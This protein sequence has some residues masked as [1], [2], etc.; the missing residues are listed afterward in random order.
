M[1]YIISKL[2]SFLLSPVLYLFIFIIL[3]FFSKKRVFFFAFTLFIFYFFT[4]PFIFNFFSEIIEEEATEIAKIGKFDYGILLGGIASKDENSH[5]IRYSSNATRLLATLELYQSGRIDTIFISAGKRDTSDYEQIEAVF[6]KKQ[7]QLY[8]V[9]E[10]KILIEYQS[11]NTHE[12]AVFSAIKLKP[13]AKN[14]TY[15]LITSSYHVRRAKACFEKEGF[16]IES[17]AADR[18]GDV[19]K[20]TINQLIPQGNQFAKWDYLIHELV[21]IVSYKL[22]G[23][24]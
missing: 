10:E 5:Q 3:S 9:A 11:A 22:M 14:S 12:N 16:T 21:G 8:G 15:L 6:L 4:C 20:L 19:P 24:L 7:L 18:L 17:F 2:L 1:F 13:K 23:Y